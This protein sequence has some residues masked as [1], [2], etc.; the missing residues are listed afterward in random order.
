[1]LINYLKIAI[2]NFKKQKLH[3]IVNVAG[4]A[5]GIAFFILLFSYIQDELT[6]DCFHEKIDNLYF[7]T[8]NIH[9]DQFTGSSNP[10]LADIMSSEFPEVKQTSRLWIIEQAIKYENNIFNHRFH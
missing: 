6:Y 10:F 3:L 2:R 1:M 4:F 9:Q 5:V 8:A 7:I